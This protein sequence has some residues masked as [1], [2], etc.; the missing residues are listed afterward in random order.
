M[1]K[2]R[3]KQTYSYWSPV[4]NNPIDNDFY[5]DKE[6]KKKEEQFNKDNVLFDNNLQ[7]IVS[8]REPGEPI[9]TQ[10]LS[11]DKKQFE[12]DLKVWKMR[13]QQSAARERL[14]DKDAVPTR[15][16]TGKK[17]FEDFCREAY[18]NKQHHQDNADLRNIFNAAQHLP[19]QQWLIF[20]YDEYS[21]TV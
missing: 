3:K 8:K 11:V 17:L 16:A 15:A 2:S 6:E 14:K 4:P 10:H 5:L 12:R 1:N 7:R 13:N 19:Y 21:G 18:K 9:R 20:L